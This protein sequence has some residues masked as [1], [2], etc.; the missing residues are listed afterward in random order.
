MSNRNK[1]HK[2]DKSEIISAIIFILL[3]F[4]LALLGFTYNPDG[5]F[6]SSFFDDVSNAVQWK[7]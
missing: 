4:T 2:F 3:I 5:T 7:K 6:S 1:R